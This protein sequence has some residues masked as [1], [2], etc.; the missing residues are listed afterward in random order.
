MSSHSFSLIPFP[1][2]GIPPEVEITGAIG[3]QGNEL[4]ITY[5]LLGPLSKLAVPPAAK[6]ATRR[7]SLWKETCFEFF[8]AA[9]DA[10]R[11]WEFNL[12]PAGYWNVYRFSSYRKGLQEEPAFTS[13]PLTVQVRPNALELYLVVDLGKII[14]TGETLRVGLGAVIKTA[15]GRK[16]YWALIHRG[17]DPDFHHRESF[18][19]QI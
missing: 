15:R 17:P 3:R 16:S 18:V 13:L 2:G 1:S 11:Y 6:V 14:P 5:V 7:K 9:G 10:D 19:I 12:S 8:I 4:S